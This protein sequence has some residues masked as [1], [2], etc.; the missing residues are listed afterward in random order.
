MFFLLVSFWFHVE[1]Y[2]ILFCTSNCL[3]G[4]FFNFDPR[5]I[6]T[7]TLNVGFCFPLLFILT[8]PIWQHNFPCFCT[9]PNLVSLIFLLF[10][11]FWPA[12]SCPYQWVF[13]FFFLPQ[14]S[15]YLIITK[16]IVALLLYPSVMECFLCF[17]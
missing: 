16:P 13:F 4:P 3:R 12:L 15:N 10:F 6:H 17:L 9:P 5:H 7:H 8:P 1:K 2:F 11:P 14:N